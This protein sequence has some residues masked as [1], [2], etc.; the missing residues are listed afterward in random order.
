MIFRGSPS[1][2]GRVL[3][4]CLRRTHYAR[5]ACLQGGPGSRMKLVQ[6]S[7]AGI[8]TGHASLAFASAQHKVRSPF[9]NETRVTRRRRRSCSG[10]SSCTAAA[11]AARAGGGVHGGGD[12]DRSGR[13]QGEVVVKKPAPPVLGWSARMG[14]KKLK[15]VNVSCRMM[16]SARRR[17][18]LYRRSRGMH[19]CRRQRHVVRKCRSVVGN[20]SGG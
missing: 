9:E 14:N 20:G 16:S 1:P 10:S 17:V 3:S 4:C 6:G 19:Q 15:Q 13:S 8:F 7:C 18:F 5:R 11:A 2:L 12:G